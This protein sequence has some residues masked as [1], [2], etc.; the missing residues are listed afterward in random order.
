MKIYS[1]RDTNT[2]ELVAHTEMIGYENEFTFADAEV[3]E[4]ILE[5]AIS[6]GLIPDGC[7][8][9]EILVNVTGYNFDLKSHIGIEI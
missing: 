2:K 8:E 7:Y 4:S 5:S 6:S 3:L 1:L 9:W